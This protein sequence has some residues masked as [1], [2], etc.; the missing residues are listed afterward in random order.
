VI[1]ALPD[2][3]CADDPTDPNCAGGGRVACG[4]IERTN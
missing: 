2:A 4:V 3:Y 1:H